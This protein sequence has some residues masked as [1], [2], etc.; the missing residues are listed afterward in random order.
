MPHV[1]SIDVPGDN[2]CDSVRAIFPSILEAIY[3]KYVPV[4]LIHGENDCLEVYMSSEK[5]YDREAC[6]TVANWLVTH[7]QLVAMENIKQALTLSE[8]IISKS[9]VLSLI[10]VLI[11]LRGSII[12]DL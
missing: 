7:G 2:Y 8:L 1:M 12:G 6:N 5:L 9:E 4:S 3:V 10:C 11:Q